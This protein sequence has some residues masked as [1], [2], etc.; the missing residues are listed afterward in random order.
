[1]NNEVKAN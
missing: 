1:M